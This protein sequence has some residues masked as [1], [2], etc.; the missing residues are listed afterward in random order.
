MAFNYTLSWSDDS[1]KP[2][3][4]LEGE[5]IDTSSTSLSLTGKGY[6][7][8]GEHVQ[9]NLIRLLENFAS[10]GVAPANPT[11]GQLWYDVSVPEL[12]LRT[13]L[14]TWVVLWP[15]PS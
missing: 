7:G 15:H 13:E 11:I 9:E 10:D 4:I 2:P 3:F 12:K 6:V 8:W 14:G 5:T 1:L